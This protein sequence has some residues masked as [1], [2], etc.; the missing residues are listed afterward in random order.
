MIPFQPVAEQLQIV[1]G[2]STIINANAQENADLFKAL[3]GGG[4][5]FGETWRPLQIDG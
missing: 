2:N 5:N 3:K 4:N 1:L